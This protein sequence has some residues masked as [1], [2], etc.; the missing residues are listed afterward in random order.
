MEEATLG[1]KRK[2]EVIIKQKNIISLKSASKEELI[3]ILKK[4]STQLKQKKKTTS[5]I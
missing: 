1:E 5:K 3:E 4:Q 2:K